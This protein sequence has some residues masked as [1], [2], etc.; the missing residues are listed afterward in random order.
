[1]QMYVL[2]IVDVNIVYYKFDLK[3]SESLLYQHHKYTLSSEAKETFIPKQ[4]QK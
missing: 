1:M 2:F 3:K 4:T